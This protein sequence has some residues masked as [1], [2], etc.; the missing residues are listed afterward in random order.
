M[1]RSR[2]ILASAKKHNQRFKKAAN[3]LIVRLFMFRIE[4][5]CKCLLQE[6][7]LYVLKINLVL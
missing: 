7:L 3:I 1:K 2:I 5:N 4:F 6:K